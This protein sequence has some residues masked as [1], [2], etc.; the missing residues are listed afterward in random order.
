MLWLAS[1]NSFY[2]EPIIMMAA[3]AHLLTF[4]VVST[5]LHH[6]CS[7][8]RLTTDTMNDRMTFI[9]IFMINNDDEM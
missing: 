9:Q 4:P 8:H 6:T 1:F 2:Q 7:A 5:V 3:L